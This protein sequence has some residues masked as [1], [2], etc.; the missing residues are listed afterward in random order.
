MQHGIERTGDLKGVADVM[1]DQGKARTGAQVS[2]ILQS[3]GNE[4]IHADH[5]MAV[6]NQSI[7]EV[8]ADEPRSPRHDDSHGERSRMGH[9]AVFR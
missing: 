7:A 6:G 5:L 9:G 4:I 1:L 8:R 3:A 2:D